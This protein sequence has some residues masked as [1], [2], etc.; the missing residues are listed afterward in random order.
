MWVILV[1]MKKTWYKSHTKVDYLPQHKIRVNH[2]KNTRQVEQDVPHLLHDLCCHLSVIQSHSPCKSFK[3]VLQNLCILVLLINFHIFH[4][5]S[6]C[7]LHFCISAKCQS[8]LCNFRFFTLSVNY[9]NREYLENH[10]QLWSRCMCVCAAMLHGGIG[11]PLLAT[12]KLW[13]PPMVCPK[14]AP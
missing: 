8:W 13:A 10:F 1:W 14:P 3:L 7:I 11:C 6:A 4:I 5:S 12:F 2:F 9:K